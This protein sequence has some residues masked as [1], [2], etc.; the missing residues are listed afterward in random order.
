MTAT[1]TERTARSELRDWLREKMEGVDEVKVPELSTAA[2]DHF[3]K[4]R[5]WVARF[6]AEQMPAMV[7]DLSREFVAQSRGQMRTM[8]DKVVSADKFK[9]AARNQPVFRK[10]MERVGDRHVRLMEMNREDLLAAAKERTDRAGTE[11]RIARL[12]RKLADGLEGGQTVRERYT[13]Q[14]IERLQADIEKEIQSKKR[15]IA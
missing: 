4:R 2:Y 10:W 8:G 14:E 6:V 9:Q 1:T 13:P 7:Y 5:D 11:I 3:T 12:W 15:E